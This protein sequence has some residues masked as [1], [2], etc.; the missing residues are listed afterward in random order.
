LKFEVQLATQH[1]S[2]VVSQLHDSPQRSTA[3]ACFKR[4]LRKI[5]NI[6][7][8]PTTGEVEEEDWR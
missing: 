3:V 4:I 7:Q 1:R 5:G 6:L 8:H 2:R